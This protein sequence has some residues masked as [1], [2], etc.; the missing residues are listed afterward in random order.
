MSCS[1]SHGEL[2]VDDTRADCCFEHRLNHTG[3]VGS[4]KPYLVFDK[5]ENPCYFS[6]MVMRL[7]VDNGS[8]HGRKRA[9]RETGFYSFTA[10]F[11]GANPLLSAVLCSVASAET[12]GFPRRSRW[13][14]LIISC[15]NSKNS[16][17]GTPLRGPRGAIPRGGPPG[18]AFSCAPCAIPRNPATPRRRRGRTIPR[19][20][21]RR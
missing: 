6:K 7:V 12:Q 1:R 3:P 19:D 10:I 17:S 4:G 13:R 20:R 8:S 21:L 2:R 18:W 9:P 15:R 14:S 16:G 11:S 5:L